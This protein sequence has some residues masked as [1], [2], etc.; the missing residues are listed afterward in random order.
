MTNHV[1]AVWDFMSLLKRLQRELT[2]VTLPWVPRDNPKMANFINSIVVG[3][4]CDDFGTSNPNNAISHYDLYL[5]S[6]KELQADE[7]P[8]TYFI[9]KLK[10]G[11]NWQTAL[12]K[13]K[14]KFPQVSE[15]TYEFTKSTLESC[16]KDKLHEVASAFLFGREDPI[17]KMFTRIVQN[18]DKEKL[19]F[20]NLK[21]YLERHIEVDGGE[22]SI[23]AEKLLVEL[24]S[25]DKQK[26]KDVENVAIK[27]IHQR[28]KLWDGIVKKLT[29]NKERV[30]I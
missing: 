17:P 5:N 9:H 30:L 20:P 19:N 7:K 2:C 18:F 23:L 10:K 13:T 3:E 28:I 11:V 1:F 27:H 29:E 24:C 21:L 4:E 6:M 26:W 25:Q 12:T 8:I 14:Q 16:D 15:H 22:H